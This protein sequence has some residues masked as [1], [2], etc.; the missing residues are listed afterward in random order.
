MDVI[1]WEFATNCYQTS[2]RR[3]TQSLGYLSQ[4]ARHHHHQSL[5]IIVPHPTI[6]KL[7]SPA[8][9]SHRHAHLTIQT[10]SRHVPRTAVA[11][12]A[13]TRGR[14]PAGPRL[15]SHP[16][17]TRCRL[18]LQQS[19][20]RLAPRCRL[21]LLLQLS[22]QRPLRRPWGSISVDS[23]TSRTFLLDR[24]SRCGTQIETK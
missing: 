21:H 7:Q 4:Q 20:R 23:D 8:P 24:I 19:P 3:M 6:L 16:L 12:A 18:P 10:N 17:Q 2:R 22:S 14:P 11:A 9:I 5:S 13:P 1:R 15:R